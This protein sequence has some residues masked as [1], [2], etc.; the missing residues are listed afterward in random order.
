MAFD[1]L[2]S[3]WDI[4]TILQ[5]VNGHTDIL[6]CHS[7][8]IC[9]EDGSRAMVNRQGIIHRLEES[10]ANCVCLLQVLDIMAL[11]PWDNWILFLEDSENTPDKARLEINYHLN[12]NLSNLDRMILLKVRYLFP[13]G[14]TVLLLATNEPAF[15]IYVGI[16]CHWQWSVGGQPWVA[17]PYAWCQQAHTSEHTDFCHDHMVCKLLLQ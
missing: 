7:N 10:K 12:C 14:G 11:H 2:K 3:M 16:F 6:H 5:S 1:K 17:P 4:H 13:G 8:G 9:P 15:F